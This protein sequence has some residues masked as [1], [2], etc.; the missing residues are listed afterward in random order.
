MNKV[1]IYC[2]TNIQS[3]KLENLGLNLV[4]VGKNTFN[5][6][7]IT[8]E[9]GKN[10][11]EKEAHYSELTFHYW[12]W[13]NKL[14]EFSDSDWIG[15]CQKRRFWIKSKNEDKDRQLKDIILKD[16]PAEW[17]EYEAVI[18]EPIKLG[19]KFMKVIK[20]GWR[21]LIKKPSILFNL[22]H[23]TIKLH[24][25][26]HHGYGVLD[27]AINIMNSEDKEEFRNYVNTKTSYNPHIMFIA[28]KK[29]MDKLKSDFE[30][31]AKE[32]CLPKNYETLDKKMEVLEV[33]E[34]PAYGLETKLKVGI[35]GVVEC[36]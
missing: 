11:N 10:I 7:Y 35:N 21:N 23:S 31:K 36:K 14:K 12:L 27:K 8:C 30:V 33:D 15:F 34:T 19:T 32:A 25:D 1:K 9:A 22:G 20:R 4:G 17:A 18:C 24:F 29:I 3:Q 6:N 5:E 13:K 2:I 28:K 26:M 16:I